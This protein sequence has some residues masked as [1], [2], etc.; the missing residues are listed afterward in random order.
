MA[1]E[2]RNALQYIPKNAAP[3]VDSCGGLVNAEEF[4]RYKFG[5]TAIA[6]K[7]GIQLA[8][9][10]AENYPDVVFYAPKVAVLTS[11]FQ[12][13]PSSSTV[14]TQTFADELT[15][16]RAQHSASPAKLIMVEKRYTE[17]IVVKE[18]YG[19]R[20]LRQKSYAHVDPKEVEGHAVFFVDDVRA[21]GA[22][23]RRI[24]KLLEPIQTASVNFLYALM[25]DEEEAS[26][27]SKLEFF[28]MHSF[29]RNLQTLS[30]IINDPNF[31]IN[32]RVCK[33][34][35]SQN[36]PHE[37]QDFLS[38]QSD[39]FLRELYLASL[40]DEL[41]KFPDYQVA[42]VALESEING[43]LEKQTA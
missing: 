7:Y 35:L 19:D 23:E 21:S 20:R 10:A 33:F 43:R 13:T 4:S 11:D 24:E 3:L 30:T 32:R 9:F 1:G 41:N 27:N 31:A 12:Q 26:R 14:L 16:I 29:V 15:R 18:H 6:K 34:F 38:R 42:W 25:F 17:E 5:D 36:N 37:I 8:R 2:R 40:A 22:Q 28:L 39:S